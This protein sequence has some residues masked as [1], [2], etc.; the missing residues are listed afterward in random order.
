VGFFRR[1]EEERTD[2]FGQPV[3]AA[4]AVPVPAG[5]PAEAVPAGGGATVVLQDAGDKKIHVIKALR[6]ATGLGLAEAKALTDHPSTFPLDP[7][8]VEGLVAELRSLGATVYATGGPAEP[9]GDGDVV[10][11]LER[12]AALRSSGAITDDEFAELKARLI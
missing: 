10:A 8:R 2:A 9:A 7:A 4:A 6:E 3:G 1:K 11:Q 5:T 12:L